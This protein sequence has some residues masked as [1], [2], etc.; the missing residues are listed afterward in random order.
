MQPLRTEDLS[1]SN[2]ERRFEG[3]IVL[4]PGIVGRRPAVLICHGGAGPGAHEAEA[5]ER[6]ARLGYA[7]FKPDLFGERFT[8]REHGMAVIQGL[9]ARPD[10]LVSRGQAALSAL[11]GHPAV[12]ADRLA[13]V[14]YCFGGLAAL[15]LARAGLPMRAAVNVHGGLRPRRASTGPISASILVCMGANDPFAP[16]E[17]RVALEAEM[18][19]RGADWQLLILSGAEHGFSERQASPRAGVAYHPVAAARAWRAT[20]EHLAE[21]FAGPQGCSVEPP[22]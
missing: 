22:A 14:G 9:M 10:E 18:T 7:A 11:A 21:A 8:S 13:A 5:A 4:D 12:N 6:L 1:Y 19:A 2:G 3:R 20:T 16:A 15:E 17:D